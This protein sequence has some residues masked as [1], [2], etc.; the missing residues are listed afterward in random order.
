MNKEQVKEN[1]DIMIQA[2]QD[3]LERTSAIGLELDTAEI[4]WERIYDSEDLLNALLLFTHVFSNLS[5]SYHL[6]KWLPKEA[7]ST[8]IE[9]LMKSFKQTIYL[10]TGIDTVELTKEIMNK[11]EAS[12]DEG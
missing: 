8:L 1:K 2:I 5:I 3:S 9:E 6:D 4:I 10:W 11:D 7:I 12:N